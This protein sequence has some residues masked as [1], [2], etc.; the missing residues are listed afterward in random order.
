MRRALPLLAA[1][2]AVAAGAAS[3]DSGSFD[4]GSFSTGSYDF[5]AGT[6]T[7]PDCTTS[8]TFGITCSSAV[9]SAGLVPNVT[10]ACSD[11]VTVGYVID[12]APTAGASVAS[13]ST[14]IIYVS[15]GVACPAGPTGIAGMGV[16]RMMGVGTSD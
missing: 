8:P 6:V 3:F 12:T 11:T 16:G 13:G 7:V 2:W 10:D 1:L 9:V 14:V 4:T 15:T 5:S